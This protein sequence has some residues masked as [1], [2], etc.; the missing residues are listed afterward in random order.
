MAVPQEVLD[1]S[2][3]IDEWKAKYATVD[4][5]SMSPY[6]SESFGGYSY[7]KSAGGSSDSSKGNPSSWQSAF[8]NRLNRW[9]KI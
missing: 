9:R 1:L 3:E 5:Q 8:S 7:S 4:S 6:N 2:A